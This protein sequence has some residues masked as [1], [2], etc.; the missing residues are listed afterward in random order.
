MTG[1]PPLNDLDLFDEAGYLRLYPGI[2]EAIMRGA[3]G[4]A[5]DHYSRHGRDEGRRPNDVDPGFYFASYP[6]VA[7]DLGRPPE[8]GDAAA[9]YVAIGRS[10]GYRPSPDAPRI[11]NGA[12]FGSP[13]GGVWTDQGNALDLIQDRLDL[14]RI[15]LREA[16]MLRTFA[17]EGFIELDPTFDTD[18]MAA[19]GLAIEQAFTGRF[20]ELLF[21]LAEPGSEQWAWR[22]ELTGQ[23]VAALDPHM[24]SREIRDI[25]LDRRVTDALAL[26][27][28]A[29]PKLTASR[30]GLRQPLAPD[31]DVA[32]AAHALPLQFVTVT[33][34]LEDNP[35]GLASVWPGSHRLPDL[36]WSR[37]HI[38]FSEAL[39]E[40]APGLTEAM[41]RREA[42]VLNLVAGREPRALA[43]AFGARTIRHAN[44]VHA[45]RAPAPPSRWRSLTGWY[46]PSHGTPCYMEAGPVRTHIHD[47]FAYSSGVYPAMDPLD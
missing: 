27:F 8:P 5:L 17:T 25:L 43:A 4:S 45:V 39:R 28:D 12:A 34:V 16:S 29:K 26:L 6:D 44:L 24:M 35:A 7:G 1:L 20:P 31:R 3:I 36:P 14:G 42:T 30:A 47:E 21:A 2:A 19:A 13:F 40:G 23:P 32:R 11:T 38:C 18:K 46:C 33:F 41:E 15:R 22:P 10:R 37:S 9:H